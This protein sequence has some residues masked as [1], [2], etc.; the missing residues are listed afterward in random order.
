MIRKSI[1]RKR[2]KNKNRMIVS[3]EALQDFSY[4]SIPQRLRWLDEMRGFL[5]KTLTPRT[6]KILEAFR[7]KGF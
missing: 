3:K 2:N 5:S 1:V 4:S 7:E 6:K